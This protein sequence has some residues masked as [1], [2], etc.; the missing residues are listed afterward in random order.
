MGGSRMLLRFLTAILDRPSVRR[1]NLGHLANR[2]S[3]PIRRPNTE[4]TALDC[5]SKQ[6]EQSAGTPPVRDLRQKSA[7]PLAVAVSA[8]NSR[9]LDSHRNNCNSHRIRGRRHSGHSR[10]SRHNSRAGCNNIRD[11]RENDR[12]RWRRRVLGQ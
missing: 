6:M 7:P 3:R 8:V 10:Y 12:T 4:P 9:I 1:L 2:H 5:L 11:R